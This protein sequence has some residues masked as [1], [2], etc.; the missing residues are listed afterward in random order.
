MAYKDGENF[1]TYCDNLYDKHIYKLVWK[2]G[3]ATEFD[4]YEVLRAYWYHYKDV[5]DRV[6][7]M[8]CIAGKGF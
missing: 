6:I 1:T 7:I 5:A 3:S 8:D 4:D 2:D